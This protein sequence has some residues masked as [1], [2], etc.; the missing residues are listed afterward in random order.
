MLLGEMY[1]AP[2]DL[3]ASRLGVNETRLRGIIARWHKAGYADSNRMGSGPSWAWLTSA[4]M[5]LVGYSWEAGP[6]K[7]ARLAHIR[8]VLASRLWMESS[9]QWEHGITVWRNERELRAGGPNQDRR[10]H[11]A[12][13]EVWWPATAAAP[14]E[15]WAVE[16]ELTPK[17]ATKTAEVIAGL[18]TGQKYTRVMY[19]CGPSTFTLVQGTAAR[20][21][22]DQAK[23]LHVQPLPANALYTGGGAS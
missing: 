2:Y 6:P 5:D 17:G 10:A 13:A 22:A 12:D 19:L 21:P 8:A 18:L 11:V 1:G 20:F 14:E 15:T 7:V 4:G 16:V 9:P 3:L 23:R